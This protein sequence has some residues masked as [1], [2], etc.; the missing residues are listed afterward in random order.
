LEV[1][2][3]SG[4]KNKNILMIIAHRGFRDEELLEPKKIFEGVGANVAIASTSLTP[5]TGM[6]GAKVAPNKL[7]KDVNVNDYDAVVFVGGAGSEV[8]FSDPIAHSIAKNAHAANKIIGAICIAPG[9]LANAG[10]LKGKKA[11]IWAGDAKYV[12]VLRSNNVSYTGEAVTKDGKII[13]AN[14]PEAAERFGNEIAK[15]MSN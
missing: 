3:M 14:G 2:Y 6:F 5:A 10:V 8:Y 13:T 12:N 15:A 1:Y 9:I 11:T 4:L 7:L